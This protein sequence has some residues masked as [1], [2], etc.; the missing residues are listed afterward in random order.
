MKIITTK[1]LI[2]NKNEMQKNKGKTNKIILEH[3]FER[4]CTGGMLVESLKLTGKMFHIDRPEGGTQLCS[5]RGVRPRFPKCGACEL[6]VASEKE[7][8]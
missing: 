2:N 4:L 3:L 8:L 1:T 7:G 5:G 6:T